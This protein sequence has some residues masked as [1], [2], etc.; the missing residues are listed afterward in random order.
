MANTVGRTLLLIVADTLLVLVSI[1][2]IVF[3]SKFATYAIFSAVD[4]LLKNL[5]K[6]YSFP[7]IKL[8]Q[9]LLYVSVFMMDFSLKLLVLHI[10]IYAGERIKFLKI[11]N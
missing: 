5:I 4:I 8:I 10:T 9:E 1:T 3:E 7:C 2:E 6:I 11:I